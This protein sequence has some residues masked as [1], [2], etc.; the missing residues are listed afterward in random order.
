MKL[1]E[2]QNTETERQ[3]RP[4]GS[5]KK[6]I[7]PSLSLSFFIHEFLCPCSHNHLSD[8]CLSLFSRARGAVQKW[9]SP[10][11]QC[12]LGEIDFLALV[13]S[14]AICWCFHILQKWGEGVIKAAKVRITTLATTGE[15]RQRPLLSHHEH[16]YSPQSLRPRKCHGLGEDAINSGFHQKLH[17]FFYIYSFGRQFTLI[18]CKWG[19]MFCPVFLLNIHN[20]MEDEERFSCSADFGFR[21]HQRLPQN[22]PVEL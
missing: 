8:F 2:L 20:R 15:E 11:S 14:V 1:C 3:W 13:L 19:S 6:R 16:C 5:Q 9:M 10:L 21:R 22:R 7:K 4:A 17:V 12:Y 18:H